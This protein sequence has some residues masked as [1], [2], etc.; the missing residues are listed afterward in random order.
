M[1]N[2][3]TYIGEDAWKHQIPKSQGQKKG[4]F[5][6][7]VWRDIEKDSEKVKEKEHKHKLNFYSSEK[8][9]V[10]KPGNLQKEKGKKI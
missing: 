2:V 5:W 7:W 9:S 4:L 8:D 3:F 1:W 6:N 10:I